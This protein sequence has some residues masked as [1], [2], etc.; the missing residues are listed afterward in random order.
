FGRVARYA[1]GRD[2]HAVMIP[3]LRALAKDLEAALGAEAK[4]AVD[5]SPLLERALAARAGMGFVGKNTCL[6]LPRRGSYAFLGEVL[7]DVDLL[8]PEGDLPATQAPA[9]GGCGACR[10]C[11]DACPTGALV[12]AYR[13]DARRCV[14]YLTIESPGA[15][16]RG[17]RAAMGAWVFG[18]DG[19]QE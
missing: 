8:G 5:Q 4:V 14:S 18:C 12:D 13:L 2:Y 15:I 9:P 11:L 10:L 16:P 7:L 6:L 3:R 17:L 1:W 19:C